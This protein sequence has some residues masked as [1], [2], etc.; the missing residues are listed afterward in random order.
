M[1]MVDSKVT[2]RFELEIVIG[3]SVKF[4]SVFESMT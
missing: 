4:V 1:G 3:K 2:S